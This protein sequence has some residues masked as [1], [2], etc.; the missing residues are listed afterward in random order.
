MRRSKPFFAG[1][2]PC[3]SPSWPGRCGDC[4]AGSRT[5]LPSPGNAVPGGVIV[6]QASVDNQGR[7]CKV[8]SGPWLRSVLGRRVGAFSLCPRLYFRPCP[9]PSPTCSASTSVPVAPVTE[10]PPPCIG[11]CCRSLYPDRGLRCPPGP[12]IANAVVR[13][14]CTCTYLPIAPTIAEWSGPFSCPLPH[15]VYCRHARAQGLGNWL[16]ER[17]LAKGLISAG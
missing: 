9:G 3:P 5:R 10:N 13:H 7:L 1:L 16:E 8:V 14:E 11:S 4:R 6:S 17:E 2:L 15:L 12:P